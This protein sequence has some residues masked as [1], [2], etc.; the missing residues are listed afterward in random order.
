MRLQL[1]PYVGDTGNPEWDNILRMREEGLNRTLR[2]LALGMVIHGSGQAPDPVTGHA[3]AQQALDQDPEEQAR[4][5]RTVEE[6]RPKNWQELIGQARFHKIEEPERWDPYELEQEIIRR[7]EQHQDDPGYWGA[8]RLDPYGGAGVNI[9][10]SWLE[11]AKRIPFAGDWLARTKTVQRADQ[12]LAKVAEGAQGWMG[13]TQRTLSTGAA[14]FIGYAV[15]A[16][17]T[18][19]LAGMAGALPGISRIGARLSPIGR[20]AFRGAASEW[21]IQG[22]GDAPLSERALNIGLGAAFGAGQAMGGAAGGAVLGAGFGAIAGGV[23][24]E[25]DPRGYLLG[26]AAGAAGG[27]AAVK[28]LGKMQRS[29]PSRTF[30]GW[31]PEFRGQLASGEIPLADWRFVDEPPMPGQPPV[32]RPLLAAVAGEPAPIVL[33]DGTPGPAAHLDLSPGEVKAGLTLREVGPEEAVVAAE[34]GPGADYVSVAPGVL[35]VV[36]SRGVPTQAQ[37][38]GPL[39]NSVVQATTFHGTANA[40]GDID[41][42][43][44]DK[45]ALFGPGYYTTEASEITGGT[46]MSVR[47]KVLR[48]QL[49]WYEQNEPW[50]TTLIEETRR[51]LAAEEGFSAQGAG[52]HFLGYAQPRNQLSEIERQL[53]ETNE[54]IRY[55]EEAIGGNLWSADDIITREDAIKSLAARH[56]ERRQ[57]EDILNRNIGMAPN[58]RPQRLDIRRPFDI[59]APADPSDLEFFAQIL[60]TEA[61][62]PTFA[63]QLRT[64]VE[65]IKA[66]I[67]GVTGPTNE[68][69]Y[70]FLARAFGGGDQYAGDLPGRAWVNKALVRRGYDGITHIG[71]GRTVIGRQHGPHQVWIAFSPHQVYSPFG[72]RE[73]A[74]MIGV[75]P[76]QARPGASALAPA[77][78]AYEAAQLSKHAAVI[79]SPA[80]AELATQTLVD[81]ADVARAVVASF[82]GQVGVVRNVQNPG[83]VLAKLGTKGL[84]GLRLIERPVVWQRTA[85]G[86]YQGPGT[87]EI[88]RNDEIT[89][90]P[91]ILSTSRHGQDVYPTLEAAQQAGEKFIGKQFDLL[92]ASG[93]EITDEMAQQYERWGLFE[94]Q[95]ALVPGGGEVVVRSITRNAWATVAPL[96]GGPESKIRVKDLLPMRSS[97]VADH[98]PGLYEDFQAFAT[99][100]LDAQTW[101]EGIQQLSLYG[102]EAATQLPQLMDEF[103]GHYGIDMESPH[104]AALRAS[105]E[106]AHIETLRS[107]MPEES[108]RFQDSMRAQMNHAL[109][110]NALPEAT[111]DDL[112]AN[113]GF[114]VEFLPGRLDV[115]IPDRYTLQHA[116]SPE[117]RVEFESEEAAREFLRNYDVETVDDSFPTGAVPLEVIETPPGYSETRGA[118]PG[119]P[120]VNSTREA[121]TMEE[122]LDSLEETL[123]RL[124]EEEGEE[125]GRLFDMSGGFDTLGMG[126]PPLGLGSGAPPPPPPP[127]RALP[128]G[129]GLGPDDFARLRRDNP[130]RFDEVSRRAASFI[131]RLA[132]PFVNWAMM[133][134]SRFKELGLET[135][136]HG[137]TYELESAYRRM[138]N[139]SRNWKQGA[140]DILRPV[141]NRLWRDGS[142]WTAANI[143]DDFDA[144][145]Y[146]QNQGF[147]PEERAAVAQWHSYMRVF[148][149]AEVRPRFPDLPEVRNYVS[150]MRRFDAQLPGEGRFTPNE[151]QW[152]PQHQRLDLMDDVELEKDMGRVIP[153]YF[154]SFFKMQEMNGPY[155]ELRQMIAELRAHP[156]GAHMEPILDGLDD[157]SKARMWGVDPKHDMLANGVHTL[158]DNVGKPFGV[159]FT[160]DDVMRLSQ[161][162][163]GTGYRVALGTVS[164]L[165]RDIPQGVFGGIQIGLGDYLGNLQRYARDPAFREQVRRTAWDNGFT[166]KGHGANVDPDVLSGSQWSGRHLTESYGPEVAE[167]RQQFASVLDPVMDLG[168]KMGAGQGI[169]GTWLDPLKAYG[170]FGDLV[171]MVLGYTGHQKMLGALRTYREAL[172]PGIPGQAYE[173]L[174]HQLLTKSGAIRYQGAIQ[175][176]VMRLVDAGDDAGAAAF[177]GSRVADSQNIYGM[178][179]QPS[180]FRRM[181]P[182]TGRLATRF[183]QFNVQT[184]ANTAQLLRDP[185]I[186]LGEK[187]LIGGLIGGIQMGFVALEAKTG[188]NFTKMTYEGIFQPAGF[189]L[190]A[191]FDRARAL[192]ADVKVWTGNTPTPQERALQASFQRSFGNEILTANPMRAAWNPWQGPLRT[193]QGTIE[194]GTAWGGEAAAR[195]L[196]MGQRGSPA[197]DRMLN[198]GYAPTPSYGGVTSDGVE[199]QTAPQTRF[200]PA[201]PPPRLPG[202]DD[203]GPRG[204]AM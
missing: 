44:F 16:A 33:P 172:G 12:W 106:Q 151:A 121:D 5:A 96:Q 92:V 155:R 71:G 191:L 82:P 22:G 160:M 195:F 161:L 1:F 157:F 61:E 124:S 175:D 55:L 187:L 158:L 181:G 79:E 170:A 60:E 52:S 81:D 59:D 142:F 164:A 35:K 6:T 37:Y 110:R 32:R 134:D 189:G 100:R 98:V 153:R 18:W 176:E 45:D 116:S 123:G 49:A 66:R 93:R 138:D 119:S 154:D 130:A 190:L 46:G 28:L 132:R 166:Q 159:R 68:D 136:F 198:Q 184:L 201:A 14:N 139:L 102:D 77:E 144:F 105:L 72:P 108:Q 29:F 43:Y 67:P 36:P 41:P 85:A 42:K 131:S 186:P 101:Q 156:V 182:V 13:D 109:E 114:E 70:N 78:A 165:F 97:G 145:R 113:R 133:L 25:G 202:V 143:E 196:L 69:L 73:S 95:R 174:R 203:L 188:W 4:R 74:R 87:V 2:Q 200:P 163:F 107:F 171:R 91:W 137:A 84:S 168:R 141:R 90:A 125:F 23:A 135:R 11:S 180:M 185:Q 50:Q 89:D 104:G 115:E 127:G 167:R 99:T 19:E 51:E 10:D 31:E 128:P 192:S 27:V 173:L 54:S 7:R 30:P 86:F 64:Q 80:L 58:V 24:D 9:L 204:G 122:T 20:M 47:E 169:A 83:E 178:A 129:G 57:L 38:Q 88:M 152:G 75:T 94:G 149:E 3:L 76:S 39:A 146:M 197:T 147:S 8:L 118:L 179:N 111:L 112:A 56:E 62:L 126:V 194:E 148:F 15:P 65:G 103:L 26:A 117:L 150:W 193:L 120:G 199:Y 40:F 177:F 140:F 48:D 34:V 183:Q 53:Q 17:L 162:T 63:E 21:M